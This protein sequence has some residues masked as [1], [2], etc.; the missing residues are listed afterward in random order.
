MSKSDKARTPRDSAVETRYILAPN[1]VNALGS[2]FGGVVMS[3]I[4]SVAAMVAQR[5][6][7]GVVVT[8]S[9]DT[10]S[11]KEPIHV[12]DHVV[13]KASV[14]YVGKT[15]MEV[16]VQ[17]T[18]EDPKTGERARATTAYLTFV[19]ID[20]HGQPVPVPDLLVE[21]DEEKRRNENARLRV[22]ARKELLRRIKRTDP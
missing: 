21:T 1:N 12:G 9:I 7:R 14:N 19:H 20:K 18:K 8:A 22:R 11:F 6:C 17:V 2:A 13:L 5:H 4:D 3:W 10:L 16:G 15:S